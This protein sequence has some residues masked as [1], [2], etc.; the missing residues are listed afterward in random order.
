MASPSVYD[1]KIN[2]MTLLN[3]LKNIGVQSLGWK[4]E[5][6]F[7]NLDKTYGNWDSDKVADALNKFHE[8]GVIQTDI[9]NIVRHKI[10][11]IRIISTSDTAHREWHVFEKVGSAFNGRL[12]HFGVV[13]PMSPIE[14]ANTVAIIDAIR[15]DEFSHEVKAYIAASC[16]QDGLY[17][18][19]PSKYLKMSDDLLQM[20]NREETGRPI[21]DKMVGDIIGRKATIA[22]ATEPVEDFVGIQ[23]AKLLAIDTSAEDIIK[24]V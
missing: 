22:S 19:K 16:H 6:L 21:N 23:A 20:M 1:P 18:L 2:P 12:A 3:I 7:A 8:T 9:P 5:T 4:P 24:N 15:P 11:A 17:T 13:E 14:C 10:Y